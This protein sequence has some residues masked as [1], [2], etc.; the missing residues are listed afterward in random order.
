MGGGGVAVNYDAYHCHYL[1]K[2]K[3]WG[4]GWCVGG[5][6]GGGGVAVNCDAYYCH[7]LAKMKY[8]FWCYLLMM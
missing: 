7:Y 2:T 3:R 5:W 4:G 8:S 6:G 1:T